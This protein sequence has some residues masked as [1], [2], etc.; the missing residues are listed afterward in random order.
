MSNRKPVVEEFVPSGEQS[1]L[2]PDVSGNTINGLGET[3]VRRPTPV[4]W[5]EPEKIAHGDVQKWFWAQGVKEPKLAAMRADREKVIG[6]QPRLIAS[7][8]NQM[9]ATDASNKVKELARKA[10]AELVGIARANPDWVFE[11]YDFDYPWIIVLGVVMEHDKLL[12]APEVTSAIEVVDKYTK[13]WKVARPVEDWILS[14]G[15]RAEASGGPSA[16]PITL[17]PAAIECGFGELGKHGSIINREHG[18]SFRLSA[19]F[20]DMPLVEDALDEFAA[21]DFCSAC[22]VCTKACPVDAISDKKQTVRGVEK[23]YVDFDKCFSYF[24]ETYGCGI[25]LGVCPWS[26]PG[27]APKL[28]DKF[29]K[30]REKKRQSESQG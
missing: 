17:T 12:T 6:L 20:T 15:W 4:M 25:C 13:G 9:Q 22:Q 1:A 24:A 3:E 28:A 21:D 16:G 2:W 29:T 7:D 14:Q 18:S 5:H 8:Q 26:T 23:W 30:R 10:G 19:V 27:R 11:G